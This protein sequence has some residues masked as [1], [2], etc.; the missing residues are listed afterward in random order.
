MSEH[1]DGVLEHKRLVAR[2]MQRVID[3]LQ[4]RAVVHDNSK[5]SPEE[6]DT[7][8]L[9]TPILK[10]LTYGSQEYRDT[11]AKLGP[12]LA[13]HYKVNSHHP[14]YHEGGINAMPPLD[15]IEMV[16]DWY[17]AIAR[18]NDGD[19]YKSLEINRIRYGMN[20]QTYA[21]VK[22]LIDLLAK[23]QRDE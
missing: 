16:C 3:E 12:A 23:E 13:H 8:E 5:F 1:I 15:R 10:T 11:L 14:E 2:Y 22:S 6:F 18:V 21:E 19:I 17:A 7:F 20:E 4:Y 9:M